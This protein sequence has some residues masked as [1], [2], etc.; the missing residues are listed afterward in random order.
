MKLIVYID[1]LCLPR[2]PGGIAAF[3]YVIYRDGVKLKE[4]Y[5]VSAEGAEASNNL[6]EYAALTTALKEII[7]SGWMYKEVEVYSDSLLLVNQ[8]SSR[9]RARG[10]RYL[11]M[12]RKALELIPLLKKSILHLDS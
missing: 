6:A 3:G 8:M 11:N 7:E 4:G 5:G 9:W 2:N 12:Y 10:G 1:G